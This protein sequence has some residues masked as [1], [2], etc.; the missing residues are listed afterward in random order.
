MVTSPLHAPRNADLS[1][2]LGTSLQIRPSG[3]LPLATKRRGGR[4]VIVNLQPTK[5]VGAR[6]SPRPNPAPAALPTSPQRSPLASPQ[7]RQADLRIHGD[8]DQVM[9]R[10]L[11]HLGLE[12]PAWDGP[13]VVPRALPTLPRPPAL[14]VEVATPKLEVK[15]EAP[16]APASPKRERPD[17]PTPPK[18]PKKVK[19]E[20]IPS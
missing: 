17:S 8:V 5:H 9:G 18:P 2:T 3:N 15:D 16:G 19:V 10:L 20:A 6:G 4:L 7:D 14:K 11:K 12:V 1:I 13:R